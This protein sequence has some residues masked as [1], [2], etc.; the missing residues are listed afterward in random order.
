M[1][2]RILCDAEEMLLKPGVSP[3]VDIKNLLQTEELREILKEKATLVLRSFLDTSLPHLHSSSFSFL[4]KCSKTFSI[5]TYKHYIYT[6]VSRMILLSSQYLSKDS[7]VTSIQTSE[8][9][10]RRI[11]RKVSSRHINALPNLL[12][13]VLQCVQK[14][15][16]SG[17]CRKAEESISNHRTLSCRKTCCCSISF[18]A[19][20]F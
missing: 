8:N 3:L 12:K 19:D 10:T 16:I 15:D 1:L 14:T 13:Q 7:P 4:N 2:I 11:Q 9:S 20:D 18:R 6:E 5:W 17:S